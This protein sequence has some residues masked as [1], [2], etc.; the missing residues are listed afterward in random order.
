VP[1]LFLKGIWWWIQDLCLWY[2]PWSP[3]NLDYSSMVRHIITDLQLLSNLDKAKQELF[4]FYKEHYAHHS[5]QDNTL[6]Q[7]TTAMSS[8]AGSSIPATSSFMVRYQRRGPQILNQLEDY[9]RLSCKPDFDG[10]D[11]LEWWQSHCKRWP[12]LYRLACDILA[13]PGVLKCYLEHS[14]PD[15]CLQDLLLL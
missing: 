2:A 3:L 4:K 15:L 5:S 8:G 12:Q 9:F 10:C 11:P 6:Q 14:S 13:I 1:L 7:S